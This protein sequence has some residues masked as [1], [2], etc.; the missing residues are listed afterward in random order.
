MNRYSV[1]QVVPSIEKIRK[2]KEAFQKE[3]EYFIHDYSE[4]PFKEYSRYMS[5]LQAFP[6]NEDED[7]FVEFVDAFY[8]EKK[9]WKFYREIIELFDYLKKLECEECV[10]RASCYENMTDEQPDK[11]CPEPENLRDWKFGLIL[12]IYLKY[13]TAE[14]YSLIYD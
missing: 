3:Y 13:F 12:F 2:I 1:S 10:V 14:K 5:A 8:N 9:A 4:E 11:D 7:D 6:R